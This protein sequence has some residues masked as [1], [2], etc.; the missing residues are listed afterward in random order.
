M[1]E[2]V[3]YLDAEGYIELVFSPDDE[4]QS[5]KGW[6]MQEYSR[7]NTDTRTSKLYE[8]EEAARHDYNKGLVEW[9][10]WD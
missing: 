10:E 1:S 8:S 2:P 4:D 9:E 7:T 3:I 5:G 6:Y